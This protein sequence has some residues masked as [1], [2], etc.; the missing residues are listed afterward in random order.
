MTI[1]EVKKTIKA[2]LAELLNMNAEEIGD[3]DLIIDDLGADSIVIV[4]LYLCCQEDFGILVSEELDL[5]I[6]QSVQSLSEVVMEKLSEEG[7]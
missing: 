5:Y 3:T 4:Q 6:S 1:E 2:H 7:R